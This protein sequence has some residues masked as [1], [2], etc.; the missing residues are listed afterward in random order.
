M[1]MHETSASRSLAPEARTTRVMSRH[2]LRALKQRTREL[3]TPESLNLFGLDVIEGE[4][5][6]AHLSEQLRTIVS[7]HYSEGRTFEDIASLLAIPEARVAELHAEALR[8]VGESI[9]V[10][11]PIPIRS[12]SYP[13]PPQWGDSEPPESA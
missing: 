3:D 5:A 13:P 1:A 4:L 9:T 7:L 12:I 11:Q 2:L 6:I 10:R 8:L